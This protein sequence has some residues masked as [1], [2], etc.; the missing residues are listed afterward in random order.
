MDIPGG[1]DGQRRRRRRGR[2]PIGAVPPRLTA[3]GRTDR[4]RPR[5]GDGQPGD[6]P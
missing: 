5:H 3:G 2:P 6:P 1:P 4:G